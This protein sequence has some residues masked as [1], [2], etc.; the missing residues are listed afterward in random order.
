MVDPGAGRGR[1]A[2]DVHA[3][4][5]V[6]GDELVVVRVVAR[7]TDDDAGHRPTA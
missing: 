4:A 3:L 6:P 5:A 1:D 2:A 7:G